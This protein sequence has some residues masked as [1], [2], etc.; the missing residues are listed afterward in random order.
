VNELAYR[1]GYLYASCAG[2]YLY[3]LDP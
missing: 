3:K 1:G 2:G